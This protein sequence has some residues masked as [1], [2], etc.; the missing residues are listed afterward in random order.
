MAFNPYAQ[1]ATIRISPALP[2]IHIPLHL[3]DA[4]NDETVNIVLNYGAQLG[5]AIMMLLVV[6]FTTPP[7]KF[8]RTAHLLHLLSLLVCIVRT[9]LLALYFESPFAHFYAVWSGD[10]SGVPSWAYRESVAGTV[11]SMLLVA[12]NDM[13]L[14]NQAWTMVSLWPTA[15]KF[16][17]C[18]ISLLFALLSVAARTAFTVIQCKATYALAPAVQ[19][20]WLV[21]AMVIINICTTLWF[22]ALFNSK[23]IIHLVT[24]RGVLPSRRAMSPMEVLVV[25]NGALMI[26]P[27][28]FAFIEFRPI[29]NFESSSLTPASISL[30]LPLG[31]LVAQRL[32]YTNQNAA[33]SLSG[34]PSSAGAGGYKNN[35]SSGSNTPLKAGSLFATST[36]NSISAARSHSTSRNTTTV[37][38]RHIVDPIELELR[39]I[40]GYMQPQ[41]TH[42]SAELGGS[43]SH[44]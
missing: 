33:P 21:H 29:L 12:I 43:Q 23:I 14:I 37:S 28:I 1:N 39:Q 44:K 13:A 17:L 38:A 4:F 24:N 9:V 6:L 18:A 40:D 35:R 16:V 5:A 19:F 3:I 25:T 10:Y 32:A 20:A 36:N 2:A 11:L 15:T 34:Y 27:V 22:C 30:I 26:I 41:E 42:I 31:S 7:S 8:L